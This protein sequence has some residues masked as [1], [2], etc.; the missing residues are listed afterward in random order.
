[1]K[2][3][4]S[5]GAGLVIL[6]IL[7]IC[8]SVVA[9]P[10]VTRVVSRMG[11]YDVALPQT[12]AGGIEC[13]S[14][15]AGLSI[16]VSF[17]RAVNGGTAAVSAGTATVGAPAFN[18]NAMTIPLTAVANPQAITLTLSN[19][20]DTVGGT[21]ASQDIFFRAIE[22]D[23]NGSGTVT[24][25]DVNLVKYAYGAVSKST[26]RSDLTHDGTV[27]ASDLALVK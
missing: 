3:R 13:R 23:V 17:D 5:P 22:G 26:F 21:L 1:M 15:S 19:V 16:V 20:T 6:G 24:V 2:R 4:I 11:A 18:G 7:C 9:Q 14:V 12:G 27:G 8:Q 25:S 10:V